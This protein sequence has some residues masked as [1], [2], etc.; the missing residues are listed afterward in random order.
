MPRG[1]Q[2]FAYVL[3]SLQPSF[4]GLRSAENG[5]QYQR[6]IH[7]CE[8]ASQ[9]IW[10]QLTAA[11]M[12]GT[13][14]A[15]SNVIAA[16]RPPAA[17]T[18]AYMQPTGPTAWCL[19]LVGNRPYFGQGG[20]GS[21]FSAQPQVLNR[22]GMHVTPPGQALGLTSGGS[23]VLASCV[24][25]LTSCELD[26]VPGTLTSSKYS[27]DTVFLQQQQQPARIIMH[28]PVGR[29]QARFLRVVTASLQLQSPVRVLIKHSVQSGLLPFVD[30][31]VLECPRVVADPK[32][33]L[34]HYLGLALVSEVGE[35]TFTLSL[36]FSQPVNG[37]LQ[38]LLIDG[39]QN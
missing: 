30:A 11:V 29:S 35:V 21:E 9:P 27:A 38:M 31:A 8:T 34:M 39:F 1:V 2:R 36:D 26:A 16:L 14:L 28:V 13:I 5:E 10:D 18:G 3:R 33:L 20:P 17:Y 22:I 15:G 23:P 12:S 32:S 4:K 25:D 19:D 37:T 24:L 6:L 7:Q